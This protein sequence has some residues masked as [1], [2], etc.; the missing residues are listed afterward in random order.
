V[1]ESFC[2]FQGLLTGGAQYGL[3]DFGLA[4]TWMDGGSWQ[5]KHTWEPATPADLPIVGRFWK[6]RKLQNIQ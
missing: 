3:C 6:S 4:Q 2:T 5:P 1:T